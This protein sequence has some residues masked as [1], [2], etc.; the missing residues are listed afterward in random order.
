MIGYAVLV[1]LVVIGFVRIEQTAQQVEHEALVRSYVN[2]MVQVETRQII[3]D[4]LDI[5][6]SR[7]VSDDELRTETYA[8]VDEMIAVDLDCPPD[9]DSVAR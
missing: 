6:E 3:A 9:P 8:R 2:C 5:F 1:A 7:P 4:I